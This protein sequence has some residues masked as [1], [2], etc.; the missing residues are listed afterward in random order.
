MSQ[1]TT[2]KHTIEFKGEQWE[3]P[4]GLRV[5][6]IDRGTTAG[7]FWLDEPEKVF[8][9]DSMAYHD[10]YYRGVIIHESNIEF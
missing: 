4:A 6:K 7:Q 2:K 5:K 8:P 1:P 3:V 10:A 9:K